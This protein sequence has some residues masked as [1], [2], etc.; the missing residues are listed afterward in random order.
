MQIKVAERV[1]NICNQVPVQ[2][3]VKKFKYKVF[4]SNVTRIIGYF[5]LVDKCINSSGR[6]VTEVSDSPNLQARLLINMHTSITCKITITPKSYC[7]FSK[8][9]P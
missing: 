4:F 1:L 2:L 8:F 6:S 3:T 7:L 5:F 9:H